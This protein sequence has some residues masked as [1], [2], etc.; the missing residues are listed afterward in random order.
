M[1]IKKSAKK[2]LDRKYL[3][4]RDVILNKMT[5]GIASLRLTWIFSVIIGLLFSLILGPIITVPVIV[6]I[7]IISE[8]LI[9][10]LKKYSNTARVFTIYYLTI[11]MVIFLVLSIWVGVFYSIVAIQ[12][13]M[14]LKDSRT[15]KLF[16]EQIEKAMLKD[17]TLINDQRDESNPYSA[18]EKI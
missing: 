3:E 18:P 17:G 6:A 2:K 1:K 13:I 8:Y 14:G 12:G 15:K 16:K 5:M 9:K 11:S 10:K 4:K 7:I